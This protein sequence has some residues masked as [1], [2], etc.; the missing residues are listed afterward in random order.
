MAVGE[1]KFGAVG[2]RARERLAVGGALKSPFP[3]HSSADSVTS[4]RTRGQARVLGSTARAGRG[5]PG[6]EARGAETPHPD[7]LWTPRDATPSKH[8][9][10]GCS[11]RGRGSRTLTDGQRDE[12]HLDEERQPAQH[13]HEPHGAPTPPAPGRRDGPALFGS[14]DTESPP[15]QPSPRTRPAD[16]RMRGA[17]ERSPARAPLRAPCARVPPAGAEVPIPG[18]TKGTAGCCSPRDKD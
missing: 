3:G 17:A 6:D 2:P 7:S 10:R 14:G 8:R 13:V 16:G 5:R 4:G 1:G 15:P 12:A 18:S 9:C 11:P